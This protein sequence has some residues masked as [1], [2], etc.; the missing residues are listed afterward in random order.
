MCRCGGISFFIW[1]LYMIKFI[2]KVKKLKFE[3]H[4]IYIYGAGAY[5]RNL[6]RILK[7]NNISINGF[8]VTAK[9]NEEYLLGLP[10]VAF[11]EIKEKNVGIILALNAFN[12]KTVTQYLMS[13]CYDMKKVLNG[14][15]YLDNGIERGIFSDEIPSM[16]IT[17]RI[18]C[19]VACPYCPQDK[20]LN[21]YYK[22]D[23]KRESVMSVETF[24]K[25]LE[26]LPQ[27]CN[28]LFSGEAE[29][30]L[31]PLCIDMIKLAIESGRNVD[32]YTTLV[33][34][35][36]KLLEEIIELPFNFVVLHVADKKQYAKIPVTDEYLKILKI[37]SNQKKK[38][39]RDF[40]DMCNAQTE[41]DERV[42]D[43]FRGKK[44]ILYTLNDRA[45][46]LSNNELYF[47]RD[48]KGKL[49]CSF[50]GEAFTHNVL[51]PD[52][53]VLVCCND[54]GMKHILGNL[55][56]QSYEEIINGEE[57]QKLKQGMK[58]DMTK[59]ILCRNCACAR[60][61]E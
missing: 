14:G 61:I 17:T 60:E 55:L 43:I 48:L 38:D 37:L 26:K 29:P 50:C 5:G 1:C 28:I 57:M 36:K 53:S 58:G 23:K 9:K 19:K 33:G 40:I 7:E 39:G 35:N 15:I 41:P 4:D 22:D 12:T 52:G 32:L 25:C 6:F 46:N 31:N 54:F 34:V 49:L 13:C 47:K 18:G 24:Q 10:I 56:L 16:E 45:G 42:V 21:A 51:L 20:F 11:K 27:N 59:D 2:E 3:T 44:E 30:F 8:I